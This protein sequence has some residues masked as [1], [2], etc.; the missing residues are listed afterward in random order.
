M[1]IDL[2]V[3]VVSVSLFCYLANRFYFS[4]AR[5]KSEKKLDGKVVVVTGS[6]SGIGFETALDFAK[7]G[8]RVILACR[9]TIR[10]EKA[11]GTII[12]QTGNKQVDYEFIDLADLDTVRSFVKSLKQKIDRLD[13][14]VNNAGVMACP[15]EW[16]TKQGYEMQFGVNYLGHFLLTNLLLDLIKKT[17]KSRV[18]SV[19]S[20]LHYY[21][22][23][24]WDCLEKGYSQSKLAVVMFTKELARR[25]D[26]TSVTAVCLH[27]GAVRTGI[28]RYTGESMC[29]LFPLIIRVFYVCYMIVT[30]N[31][32]EGSMTTIYCAL[33]D[34][35]PKYNGCYFSDCALKLPSKAV[36][37]DQDVK[38]TLILAY[39]LNKFY[40]SGARCYSKNRLDGK[41]AIITG[42]NTGIG[43]QTALDFAQRGAKVILACRDTKKAE[44]AAKQIIDATGNKNVQVEYIDLADLD[45]VQEF[46]KSMKAKLTKLDLLVNN[47]G[48]MFCPNW[49]TKQGFEMQFGVNHLGHFLLTNLLLDLIKK[50]DK[51]RIINVS[52][53]AHY[54][55]PINWNDINWE[56]SYNTIRAYCQSKTANILFTKELASRLEGTGITVVA[57]H[58]GA[59]I[60]E[61]TRYTGQSILFLIPILWKILYPFI[62]IILKTAEEGA[63]TTIYCAVDECVPQYT[64]CY[65]SD[66]RPKKSSEEAR[67]QE[68]AKKLWE[69]SCQMRIFFYDFKFHFVNIKKRFIKIPPIELK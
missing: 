63:Q 60:T 27:P 9:D 61:L 43:Y 38:R 31:T 66:C 22:N 2:I 13:L 37:N 25:L 10:A 46:A 39:A 44:K 16:R 64:G 28:I 32:I 30:K 58:P 7:R 53:R 47:A 57:L 26:G 33:D 15:S 49:R 12:Q 3:Y 52:S 55:L 42:S 56:K 48:I 65:M 45:T 54:D 40:F 51:A 17:P 50:A 5:Y 68:N 18:I 69:I 21:G 67:S 41:T 35:V 20:C 29:R 36:F 23:I 4:G 1:L 8:A 19:S 34:E 6:D 62:R 59:V 24:E 14:L 11:V